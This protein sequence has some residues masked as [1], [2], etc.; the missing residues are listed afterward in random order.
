M[1]SARPDLT[2]KPDHNRIRHEPILADTPWPQAEVSDGNRQSAR[3]LQAEGRE[4]ESP[5][6]TRRNAPGGDLETGG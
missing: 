5:S 3:I 4:F 2:T 1:W 6:S